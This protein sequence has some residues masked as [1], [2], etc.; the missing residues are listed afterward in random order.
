MIPTSTVARSFAPLTFAAV[1]AL[2]LPARAQQPAPSA[3]P[4]PP[5]APP[6]PTYAT[7][8]TPA[9][10]PVPAAA[11]AYAPALV[12]AAPAYAPA[13]ASAPSVASAPEYVERGFYGGLS[14]GVGGPFGGNTA[15]NV[16]EGLGSAVVLGW[17][18]SP[19]F[20]IDT[21][22]HYN[23]TR[24]VYSKSAVSPASN[25][26]GV[27]LYGLELR[28]MLGGDG[29]VKGWASAGIAGGSG[30]LEQSDSGVTLTEDV[31]FKLM[32]VLAFGVEAKLSD[33][34]R[35]GPQLRYYATGIDKA[36]ESLSGGGYRGDGCAAST[37]TEVVPDIVYFGLGLTY[38]QH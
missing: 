6:A 23:R 17:A 38:Y 14:L 28:L 25:D 21:F 29:P 11:P 5:A 1:T 2:A 3:P 24:A 27:S 33:G 9:A 35:L 32:P 37:D 12:P 20:G 15:V 18:F 19:H 34:L 22:G 7:L 36:C 26:G 8:P 13:V 31:D 4:V 10:A 16:G 30:K